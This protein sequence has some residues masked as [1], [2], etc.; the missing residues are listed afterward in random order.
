MDPIVS[1]L[2]AI[3]R[4]LVTSSFDKQVNVK[5]MTLQK[6]AVFGYQTAISQQLFHRE[7]IKKVKGYNNVLDVA[8]KLIETWE[9][10]KK[11][12]ISKMETL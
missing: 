11:G 10:T 1:S 2:E 8:N 7:N 3:F 9:I 4:E 12:Q 6:H 5:V